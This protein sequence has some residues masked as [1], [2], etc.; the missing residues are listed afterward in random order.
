[1]LQPGISTTTTTSMASSAY[2]SALPA[3]VVRDK[4]GDILVQGEQGA[5]V[6]V[7]LELVEHFEVSLTKVGCWGV[8][9]LLLD[10]C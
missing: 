8:L 7:D 5:Q 2:S 4:V 9:G 1:M 10:H 3:G 6:L